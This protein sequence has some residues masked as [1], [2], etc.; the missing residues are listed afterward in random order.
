MT[1]RRFLAL[2]AA[3]AALSR[4]PALGATSELRAIAHDAY[5]YVL[6]LLEMAATRA[7][8]IAAGAAENVL[9]TRGNL[10][11]ASTRSVT[12]PNNDTLISGA[13][14][15][16]TAG[17]AVFTVRDFGQR[18]FSLA[19]MDMFTNNFAVLGTRTTGSTAGTFKL[20]GPKDA[21]GPAEHDVIRSPTPH[22]WALARVLVNGPD[23]LDAARVAQ[24]GIRLAAPSS[25]RQ[26]EAIATQAP[27]AK[28]QEEFTAA[29][30][31][32]AE[33]RP[34]ATDRAVLL[35]IAPLGVGPD[36]SFK[37]EAFGDAD[38]DAIESGVADAQALVADVR[39]RGIAIQGWYY[40]PA[41]LGAFGQDY[42]T[43][44]RVARSGLA[45]LPR[46]EA[47]YM[48]AAGENGDALYDGLKM[49]RLHFAVGQL[50]PVKAFW[51]LSMYERTP[52]GRSFF[53]ENALKRYAIGDRTPGLNRYD[54]G[55]L[56]IWIGHRHPGPERQA[57]WLPA[58]AGPFTVTLRAYL[59]APALLNGDYRLPAVMPSA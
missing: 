16:L 7:K 34:P 15:D 52:D 18:Y 46:E 20:V 40:P 57:N 54:D 58:P 14:I 37:P 12:T 24:A 43:R 30:R 5:L 33:D 9:Y 4:S 28:W 59:P 19:L 27:D 17:P 48:R 21:I 55:S 41:T 25:S 22:V 6:P 29:N 56:D 32:L 51:S 53:T 44:A 8:R 50:P 49:W 10:A 47:M 31:L 2:S 35:R 11:D 39:S 1:R 36:A 13:W 26:P 45:A 42:I 38:R 23:D 3:A